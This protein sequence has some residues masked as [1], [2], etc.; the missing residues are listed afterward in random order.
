MGWPEWTEQEELF[1]SLLRALRYE[2]RVTER[3]EIST[4]VQECWKININLFKFDIWESVFEGYLLELF[5]SCVF[6][7]F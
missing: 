7:C 5:G 4:I 3:L 6:E 2:L 1:Q